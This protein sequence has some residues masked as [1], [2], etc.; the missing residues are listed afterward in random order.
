MQDTA[1]TQENKDSYKNCRTGGITESN[2]L[3]TRLPRHQP[4]KQAVGLFFKKIMY[5]AR[6]VSVWKDTAVTSF[7]QLA[8][9]LRI[10]AT[11]STKEVPATSLAPLENTFTFTDD[12]PRGTTSDLGISPPYPPSTYSVA[13]AFSFIICASGF[14]ANLAMLVSLLVQR[15]AAKK[16]VNIFICNQ[17]VLDLVATFIT[18]VKLSLTASGYLS[19]KTGVLRM[20]L[21]YMKR[22]SQMIR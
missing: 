17:T 12:G 14:I 19:K 21:I 3:T 6:C 22:A 10:Q 5:N 4:H 15:R 20:L 9:Q 2:A 8:S 13:M 18:V 11:M 7:C 1:E 16:T